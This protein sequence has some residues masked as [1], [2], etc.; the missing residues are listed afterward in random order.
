LVQLIKREANSCAGDRSFQPIGV[1]CLTL[2]TM[3]EL[4]CCSPHGD[5]APSGEGISGEGISGEAMEAMEEEMY[6]GEEHGVLLRDGPET[7]V[8]YRRFG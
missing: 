3:N 5:I 1:L 7:G 4:E 2:L 6:I 8:V